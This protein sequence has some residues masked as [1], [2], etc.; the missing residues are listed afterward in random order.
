[1]ACMNAKENTAQALQAF[2]MLVCVLVIVFA[3][4]PDYHRIAFAGL[5]W[6][7][8]LYAGR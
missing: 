8:L 5:I 6:Y 3:D 2:G 7:G 4:D 1:M